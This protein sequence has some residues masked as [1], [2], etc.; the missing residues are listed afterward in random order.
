[1]IRAAVAALLL[2]GACSDD[3][4]IVDRQEWTFAVTYRSKTQSFS[5]ETYGR[6]GQRSDHPSYKSP[7]QLTRAAVE[8]ACYYLCRDLVPPGGDNAAYDGCRADCGKEARVEARGCA[9]SRVRDP[10]AT[11]SSLKNIHFVPGP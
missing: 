3:R 4:P 9:T 8:H 1:M 6:C 7:E 10:E 5:E 2:V 11:P